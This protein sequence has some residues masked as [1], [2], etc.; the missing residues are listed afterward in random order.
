MSS[1]GD[2][3]IPVNVVAGPLPPMSEGVAVV[4]LAG[5]LHAHAPGAECP[6]CASRADV[7]T[8][9]FNLLEEARLGLRPEPLEVIVDAG[10]PERAERARAALSGLLPAT[11]LRDHRVARRFVLKA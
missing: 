4:T 11:G 3:R 9:L 7:R 1:P 5:A 8:A 2:A 6:A 10:S